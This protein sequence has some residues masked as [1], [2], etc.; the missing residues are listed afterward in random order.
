MGRDKEGRGDGEMMGEGK[1]RKNNY[2]QKLRPALRMM[3]EAQYLYSTLLYPVHC[4]KWR[5]RNDK[6]FGV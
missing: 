6:F 1:P 2:L 4:N 3:K 5:S